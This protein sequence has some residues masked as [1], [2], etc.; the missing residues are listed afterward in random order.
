MRKYLNVMSMLAAMLISTTHAAETIYVAGFGGSV[1]KV[2]EQ[3]IIPAFEAKTGAKVVYVPGNSADTMAKLV[4]QKGRQDLSVALMDDAFMY[5]A[6]EQ[7]VCASLEDAGSV[8]DVYPLARMPGGKAVGFG[9]YGTGLGY[10]TA[11]FARNGWKAP[12]SWLDLA[13]PKYKGKIA[14]GSIPSYGMLALVMMARATGGSEDKIESGFDIMAK[15][16]A[17]NVLAWESSPANTAQLLQTGE[18][19]LVVWGNT[20]VQNVLEQGAPV[21]FV[22]PKEGTLMGM[23]AACVVNGAPQS[24]L[25]QLFVQEVLSPAGQAL[26]A[27]FGGLGPANRTVKLEPDVARKVVYGPEQAGALVSVNWATINLNRAEW[28]KRWNREVER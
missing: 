10:N 14:I 24:K 2:F 23:V 16:V 28:T 13:D 19:A 12:T 8:K 15:K 5:M 21:A 7:G 27:K 18:A 3:T 11:V 9:L 20:R 25:G 17:P 4:A 1:Q 22:Y 6:M 26:L